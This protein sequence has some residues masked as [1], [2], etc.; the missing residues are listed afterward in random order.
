M[1][2]TVG[3]AE[4]AGQ[5]PGRNLGLAGLLL[6][7][8]AV[9]ASFGLVLPLA[10]QLVQAAAPTSD[11]SVHAGGLTG[12]YM[13]AIALFAPVWGRMSDHR[14]RRL[15]LIS[16]LIG[17]AITMIALPAIET[18]AQLYIQRF[19]SGLFAGAVAPAAA[20]FVADV[21]PSDQWR[22]SRMAWLNMSS[23]AGF[24]LGPSLSLMSVAVGDPGPGFRSVAAFIPFA[25]AA[26]AA[27]VAAAAIWTALDQ[28]RVLT[29]NDHPSNGRRDMLAAVL[30]GLTFTVA[31]IVGAFEVGIALRGGGL[32]R[33]TAS[34]IAIMFSICSLVMFGTQAMLF[35]PLIRPDRTWRF[36]APALFLLAV[37]LVLASSLTGVAA[38][39]IAVGLM[40]ASAGAASPIL[41]Y[42]LSVHAGKRQG[43]QLGRQAAAASLGQ[44][45][46]SAGGGWLLSEAGAGNPFLWAAA[47]AL[48]SAS[49]ALLFSRRLSDLATTHRARGVST[50]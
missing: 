24:V 50:T 17:F 25:G 19:L 27:L 22:A 37:A 5:R 18:L 28:R 34:D 33:A 11:V 47:L 9:S 36:L 49:V 4:G 13:L 12:I 39:M 38:E 15:V 44:A 40:A 26:V 21:A 8:F 10:P 45:L 31:A 43:L 3:T 6:A 32:A 16:G 14:G 23:I 2:R 29:P 30:L 20:A 41:A 1:I 42:W 7:T 35:S 46:G 48:G